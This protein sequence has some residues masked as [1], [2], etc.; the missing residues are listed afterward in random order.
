MAKR[1]GHMDE[2]LLNERGDQDDRGHMREGEPMIAS[3]MATWENYFQE[4]VNL[5]APP[6]RP[7]YVQRWIRVGIQN[8]DDPSNYAKAMRKGWKPRRMDDVGEEF[9]PMVAKHGEFAG[10]IVSHGCVLCERPVAVDALEK[11]YIRR[12]T[13]QQSQA[14]TYDLERIEDQK[15]MPVSIEMRTQ[16]QRGSRRPPVQPPDADAA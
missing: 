16:V 1:S 15:A 6:A 4:P 3:E 9:E 12:R 2:S 14:V 8:N 5:H 13:L 11:E 7:G 10:V